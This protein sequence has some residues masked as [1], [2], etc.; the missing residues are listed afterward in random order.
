MGYKH[1]T[2]VD[3]LAMHLQCLVFSITIKFYSM[4][5]T[6]QQWVCTAIAVFLFNT[7]PDILS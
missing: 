6:K 2:L 1:Y 5:K 3:Y 7:F 4:C